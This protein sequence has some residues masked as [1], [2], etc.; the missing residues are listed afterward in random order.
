[1]FVCIYGTQNEFSVIDR[2]NQGLKGKHWDPYFKRVNRLWEKVQSWDSTWYLYWSGAKP[3]PLPGAGWDKRAVVFLQ[4]RGEAP[5]PTGGGGWDR[6][7]VAFM[8]HTRI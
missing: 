8:Q 2:L 3:R 5:P 4:Q 7:C 6:R 1:V